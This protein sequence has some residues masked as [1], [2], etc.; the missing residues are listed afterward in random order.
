MISTDS[1]VFA[2]QERI[3]LATGGEGHHQEYDK[4]SKGLEGSSR[5]DVL[6]QVRRKSL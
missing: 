4:H 2:K 6:V 3:I 5:E 1:I